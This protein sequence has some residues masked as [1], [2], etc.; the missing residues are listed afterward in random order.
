MTIQVLTVLQKLFLRIKITL[1]SQE[2]VPNIKASW[3]IFYE[4]YIDKLIRGVHVFIDQDVYRLL[5]YI[6]IR[7]LT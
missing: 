2:F 3:N 7:T 6:G 1:L 4:L 5:G